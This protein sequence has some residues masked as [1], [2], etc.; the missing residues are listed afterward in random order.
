MTFTVVFA[1]AHHDGRPEAMELLYRRL[2]QSRVQPAYHIVEM[3][4]DFGRVSKAEVLEYSTRF[5]KL[6]ARASVVV[7]CDNFLPVASCRKKRGWLS[8]CGMPAAAIRSSGMMRRT[9]FRRGIM[10]MCTGT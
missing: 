6:Y 4:L 8:S 2:K 7:V 1:D 5:M 10:E 3:Y 9:I